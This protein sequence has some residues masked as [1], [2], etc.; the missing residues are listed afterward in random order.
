[1]QSATYPNIEA[2]KDAVRLWAISLKREFRVVKS[3]S[4][5]YEVKC[6]NDGCPWRVHAFMGRWKSNWKCSIVTEHTC[7]LSEVLPSH[8]NISCD[9]VA[10]QIYGLI[11]D[12]L[13]YESKMIVRHI[14]QTYLYTISYLK[15]WRAKQRVFEM[16]FGT[17]EASYDTPTPDFVRLLRHDCQN[18]TPSTLLAMSTARHQM[19]PHILPSPLWFGLLPPSRP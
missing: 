18:H 1:V 7:L 6:V 10:K 13:N 11:M 2:V 14:E 5:E 9:F 8:C 16:R 12:N 15:A 19:S 17:Y 3:D 4:K